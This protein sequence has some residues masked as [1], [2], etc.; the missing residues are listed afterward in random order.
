SRYRKIFSGNDPLYHR[1]GGADNVSPGSWFGRVYASMIPS[2]RRV[3]LVP[4][5]EGGTSL[6]SGSAWWAAGTPG[7]ALFANAVTQANLAITAAVAKFPNSRFVGTIWIQ[8]ESDGDNSI[9]QAAYTTALKAVISGFRTQITGATN[10][11][12]VIGGMCPEVIASFAGYPAIRDAHIQTAA[13]TDRCTYVAGPTGQK[14]DTY[15]YTAEGSRIIGI[16]MALAVRAAQQYTTS[17][18]AAP[19][20]SSAT[21]AHASPTFVDITMSEA[22]DTTYTPASS[23]VTIS[24]H[25]VSVLAWTSATNLR[26]T[27]SAGFAYGE[28]ARTAAYIQPG[29]NNARDVAGN[30]LANFSGL[31]ITNNV[32]AA[33]GAPTI[34]TAT[35]GNASASIAFSAPA[36]NGGSAITGYTLT[37]SPG[38][39]TG[40]G[41]SSP[42]VVAGLT[43]GTPYT[44]TATA[45]N[46]I[47]TSAASA[48][49]NSVTPSVVLTVPGAPTI[50]TATGG[51][52]QASV[53][54][55][56][57]ASDGGAAIT[58]YTLTSSPGGFTGS[59]ASSPVVVAGLANGTAYT[60]TATATNSVGTGAASGA[61]N[62]VTPATVPGAPTI[63]TATAGDTTIS[64]AF[65][66][67]GSTG[68]SAITGYIASAYKVSDNTLITTASGSVSPISV[69]GLTNGVATYV[70]V[71]AINAVGT[72]TQ[73]AASNNATPA[74]AAYATWNSADKSAALTLSNGDKTI[75]GTTQTDNDWCAARSTI[76][77][78]TGKW[79][80]EVTVGVGVHVIGVGVAGDSLATFPG[81]NANGVGYYSL[82]SIF[83]NN[84]HVGSGTTQSYTTGDVIGVAYDADAETVG[85]FK[86]GV[87][88]ST[89]AMYAVPAGTL[90]AVNASR[91]TGPAATTTTNFGASAF[92]HTPPTG[93][94][95]L[96]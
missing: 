61:S 67:P 62:S 83:R 51:N 53:T 72:G 5:G 18:V 86:N 59:G 7:G 16:N 32:L 78:T 34:G 14:L 9:T 39:L 94:V 63:G 80:W 70:K 12:F 57:P 6:V 29:V 64:I 71:A 49:S 88:V 46:A 37:S 27:V 66:A 31:T 75:T 10:S 56:A 28:A 52:G 2:N 30:L 79:Y 20:A 11:F 13:E 4:C 23:A 85:F 22:M 15:H 48:A 35:A 24:G 76:S 74:A 50:G 58:G 55:T 60:F 36:S 17:D 47:G 89:T 77:K 81:A 84:V 90:F 68:G 26:A 45:T 87:Q 33:P 25:T 65:T 69:T 41:A 21:V 95:G 3:L 73:S 91:E 38:G 54:F 96:Q 93:H 82:A 44:F 43:N 8:G 40:T 19:T 1:E 42:I 92:A